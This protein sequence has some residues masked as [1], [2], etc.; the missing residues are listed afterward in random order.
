MKELNMGSTRGAGLVL[1]AGLALVLVTNAGF[2]AAS[3]YA[4]YHD[5]SEVAS[6]LASWAREH[7]D[8]ARLE[9]A[10]DS[11]G[12]HPIHVLRLAGPGPV[13]PDQRPAVFV[14]ANVAG[15]HNAGTEAA[16]DLARTLIEG[17]GESTAALVS[18]VT[19]YVAPILNPDAH[20][21]LFGA[22]RAR[23]RGN[24]MRIDRDRDG[25]E[26][27]DGFDDLDGDGRIT[28][29]RIPDPAGEWLPH[30]DEPRLM[31]KQDSARGWAG[32][33]RLVREGDDDDGDGSFN[34]D[35]RE[36]I[37]VD[38]N[39]PH[40]FPYPKAEAG[41]WASYA[42]EAKAILDALFAR[43]NVAV[44]VV[45]GPANNLLAPPEGLGQA[46]D[47]GSQKFKVPKFAAEMLGFDPEKEYTLDEVWEVAK[48]QAFVRRQGIT[49]QQL[50][51]FLGAGPATRFEG[52]D[53]ELL[54]RV[55]RDYKERLQEAGLDDGR[56]AAQSAPGGMAPWLYYQFGV[57][58]LEL[59]VWGVPTSRKAGAG[60]EEPLTLDRLE[61]MT[62]EEFLTIDEPVV[63]AF[64]EEIG[65]PPQFTAA[66]LIERIEGGQA[67]P[68]QAA[69][70]ARQMGAGQSGG[71]AQEDDEKIA[72]A[73]EV[74]AWLDEHDPEALAV[75]TPVTLK[76][77]TAAQTGGRDP[78][79]EIAP[80][81]EVL[82]PA[83]KAHT[84]TILDLA[85]R[86]ARIEIA[87]LDVIDLGGGVHR[88]EAVA[89]NRGQLPSHTKMA[90]R[91]RSRLPVRLELVTGDGVEL[92]TGQRVRS[93]ERLDGHTG[94]LR[95][96]WL[97][98]A[99]PGAA[100]T[101][102]AAS[103]NAGGDEKTETVS[104]GASR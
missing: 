29:L 85:T 34:E 42:P 51:Q 73:R 39:F 59:D 26:A 103:E 52:D 33:H 24:E 36:G 17:A 43:R 37:V 91:A 97:V 49:K 5:R 101:V 100:V 99:R 21:G 35:P 67:T 20:D 84:Q 4:E 65:A 38:H 23:R 27:E 32:S 55:A 82:E 15:D 19:F 2:A 46:V 76:D 9:T 30:P 56:P 79:A 72:R 77:G 47:L 50:A 89:V 74:L 69:K 40:A 54:K 83:L 95:G 31:I 71:G 28:R 88:I 53:L 60:A 10:G 93:G 12:G 81:M 78:F 7:P 8:L 90:V 92:V 104:K 16:L 75:W 62:R 3:R 80:P 45:Y 94:T 98:R 66:R 64:L 61:K 63:A 96:E 70:M 22:V 6:E 57:L 11:A 41:P 87:S 102:R 14:G 44:A 1:A 68:E 18:E 13:P 25:F 48:D 58:A 86:L